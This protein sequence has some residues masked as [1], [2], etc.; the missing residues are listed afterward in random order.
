MSTILDFAKSQF[1]D[2]LNKVRKQETYFWILHGSV[3]LLSI[4]TDF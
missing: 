1:V 3:V 2:Y 4:T